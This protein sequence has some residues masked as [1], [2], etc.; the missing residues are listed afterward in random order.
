[1]EATMGNAVA[2]IDESPEAMGTYAADF[3]AVHPRLAEIPLHQVLTPN[4]PRDVIAHESRGARQQALEDREALEAAALDFGM[5]ESITQREGAF[6]Y[7][8]SKWDQSRMASEQHRKAWKEI[9]PQVYAD[10][11]RLN[12]ACRYAYGDDADAMRIVRKVAEGSRHSDKVDDVANLCLL[13]K[14]KP[15]ALQRINFPVAELEVMELRARRAGDLLADAGVTR[16]ERTMKD[17]RD[18]AYTYLKQAVDAI[19]DCGK[20]VFY[21]DPDK[22]AAYASDFSRRR[23]GG[24]AGEQVVG[25]GEAVASPA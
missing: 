24:K 12:N 13:G 8:W 21:T 6:V 18:R 19:R 7:A 10:Y 20:Y 23:R 15:Q 14:S 4:L 17:I 9:E 11:A 22:A 2:T 25:T 1:M 16:E 5:V 3:E